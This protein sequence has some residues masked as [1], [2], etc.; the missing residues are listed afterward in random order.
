MPR[1][2]W[3]VK[4]T[5]P[6]CET[7]FYDLQ[8]EPVVCP[9]CGTSIDFDAHGLVSARRER[10][11]E[12]P[13]NPAKRDLVDDEAQDDEDEDED[14][15]LLDDDESDDDEGKASGPALSDEDDDDGVVAFKDADDDD[16]DDTADDDDD[17]G[18][19][20]DEEDADASELKPKR[21]R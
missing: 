4:R 14:E 12:K 19:I 13:T 8:K 21:K 3:G 5:C 10:R 9:E 17:D 2:E 18:D 20:D 7:R 16:D 1:P 11:A 15:P 6:N